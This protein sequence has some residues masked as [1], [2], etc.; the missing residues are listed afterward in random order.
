MKEEEVEVWPL[1]AATGIAVRARGGLQVAL[2]GL[3]TAPGYEALHRR[4]AAAPERR[5]LLLVDERALLAVT[6]LSAVQAAVR[7]TP[8]T[9]AGPDWAVTIA[10]PPWRLRWALHHCALMAAEGLCRAAWVLQPGRVPAD[11]QT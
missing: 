1:D 3:V 7:G 5:R 9:Q 2:C 11:L 8:A 6:S 10:V 4:L